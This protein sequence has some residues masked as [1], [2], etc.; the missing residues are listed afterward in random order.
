MILLLHLL[1]IIKY[2][3]LE[4]KPFL[5][6]TLC[7]C[8]KC[9]GFGLFVRT[10]LFWE[11]VI[12]FLLICFIC[13]NEINLWACVFLFLFTVYA[14]WFLLSSFVE[15]CWINHLLICFFDI[16]WTTNLFCHTFYAFLYL[17]VCCPNCILFGSW[18]SLC[19][20]I[21]NM[22]IFVACLLSLIQYIGYTP[23]NPKWLRCAW[24]S[25]F[26]SKY[27]LWLVEP[28]WTK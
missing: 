2:L 10:L 25:N 16:I 27:V 1:I 15:L 28:L 19:M 18:K 9:R 22:F 12:S 20:L 8:E 5:F 3:T 17:L 4:D 7:H 23:S 24:N 14:Q 26:V 13:L 21:F 11:C 6:G